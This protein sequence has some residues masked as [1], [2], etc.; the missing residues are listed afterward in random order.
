[1]PDFPA[2]REVSAPGSFEGQTTAGVGVTG[3]V[4]FRVL[5]LTGPT[6]IVIDL[7][8]PQPVDP[9]GLTAPRGLTV[10]PAGGPVGAKGIVEGRGCGNL[11]ATAQPVVHT[12]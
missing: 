12:G 8:H 11:A 4:G 7:A 5:E 2:L 10:T 1:R 6:R 3:K 9:G